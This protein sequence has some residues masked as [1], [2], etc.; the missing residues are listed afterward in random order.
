MAGPKKAT[1][2]SNENPP[3]GDF[4][5]CWEPN[6]I[7]GAYC[8]KLR[9][10]SPS[11]MKWSRTAIRTTRSEQKVKATTR[12]RKVPKEQSCQPKVN[13][14]RAL[15][16]PEILE[17]IL[18]FAVVDIRKPPD[19]CLLSELDMSQGFVMPMANARNKTE[20]DA[21]KILSS[22]LATTQLCNLRLVCRFWNEVIHSSPA[23]RKI[24]QVPQ[25]R[26]EEIKSQRDTS[27]YEEKFV[28]YWFSTH[29]T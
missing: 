7:Q 11:R 24:Q 2:Y 27:G 4:V 14:F 25:R 17:Q 22:Y 8:F 1:T 23:F 29:L 26:T 6:T 3:P 21:A 20:T 12:R 15:E 9:N 18:T 19:I 13:S 28:L 16:S 10:P 5:R